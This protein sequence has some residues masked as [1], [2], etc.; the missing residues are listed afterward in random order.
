MNYNE[1]SKLEIK[2]LLK[3]LKYGSIEGIQLFPRLLQLIEN[4]ES[5]QQAFI[6]NVYFYLFI[7][8]I[9]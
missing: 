5:N 6:K 7:Y 3:A 9:K 2:Y 8:K 1:Y 4:D